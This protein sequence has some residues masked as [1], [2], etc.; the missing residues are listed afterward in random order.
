MKIIVS[1][2]KTQQ[3]EVCLDQAFTQP[4]FEEESQQLVDILGGF[5]EKKIAQVMKI[6]GKLLDETRILISQ[7]KKSRPTHGICL[8]TGLVFKELMDHE[9]SQEELSYLE[10]HVRILSALYGV[11]HPFDKVRPYRL[12]MKMKVIES[13]LYKYWSLLINDYFKEELIINLASDEF[14]KLIKRPMVTISFKEEKEK[15]LYKTI[16]TYSKQARGNMLAWL[17]ANQ[18]N[19]IE[20]LKDFNGLGYRYNEKISAENNLVFTRS[21]NFLL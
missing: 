18:I 7:Y 9:F 2:A 12:D 6:Q 15:S 1:P 4:R 5:S 21:K 19:E 13:G 16:G 14:S 17:I 10:D 20:L 8:Y 3:N 11:V